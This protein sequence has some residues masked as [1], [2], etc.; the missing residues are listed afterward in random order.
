MNGINNWKRVSALLLCL[1]LFASLLPVSA[2][3]A[4][5]FDPPKLVSIEKQG[6][7]LV[8]TWEKVSGAASYGVWRQT[9]GGSW[10]S[11]AQGVSGPTY[12]DTTVSGG[13]T[14]KYTV[15][16]MNSAGKIASWFDAT[17]LSYYFDW[18][19]ATPTLVSGLATGNSFILK[20]NAVSGASSYSIWR[21]DNSGPWKLVKSGVKG[22]SYTDTNVESGHTYTYT[23]R[24]LDSS[25]KIVSYFDT[26][27]VS[28]TISNSSWAYSTPVL[29]SATYDSGGIQITWDAVKN[30]PYYGIWRK[31]NGGAWQRIGK[32]T[33]TTY[34]DTSAKSGNS[35]IYTVRVQDKNGKVLS[36]FD[37]TGISPTSTTFST[38]KL[39]S[40]ANTS[41]GVELVWDPVAGARK[42]IVFRRDG[43]GP[44]HAIKSGV[45]TNS[46][47]DSNV[48]SGIDY[49]YTVRCLNSAGQWASGFESPG[50]TIRYFPHATPDFTLT[51]TAEGMKIAWPAVSGISSYR[52]YRINDGK[53]VWIDSTNTN[54]YVDKQVVSGNDYTYAVRCQ[55]ADH[56]TLLSW[57]ESNTETYYGNINIITKVSYGE[58]VTGY[59]D[60]QFLRGRSVVVEWRNIQ[61]ADSY[62]IFRKANNAAQWQ[63]LTGPTCPYA[64]VPG[65]DP[66]LFIDNQVVSG[67]TYKYAVRAIDSSG[68]FVGE[69]DTVG[70]TIL[71]YDAPDI[72]ETIADVDGITVSWNPVLG[73]TQYQVYRKITTAEGW[74]LIGSTSDLYFTDKDIIP[75][76]EYQYTVRCVGSDGKTLV[77][78][79]DRVAEAGRTTASWLN[80]PVL[81]NAE[82]YENT[83]T[84]TWLGV[85]LASRYE[86][87]RRLNDESWQHIAYVNDTTNGEISYQD[88]FSSTVSGAVYSYTVR[89]VDSYDNPISNYDK[90]GLQIRFYEVPRIT[91][92]INKTDGVYVEWNTTVNTNSYTIYRKNGDNNWIRIGTS[93]VNHFTDTT[94]VNSLTYVYAISSTDEGS[95]LSSDF[96][97]DNRVSDAITYYKTPELVSVKIE[98]NGL[99]IK[100]AAVDGITDYRLYRKVVGQE[101]V[102]CIDVSGNEYY[103]TTVDS[104][105]TYTYTVRCMVATDVVSEY[106]SNLLKQLYLSVP[107]PATITAP[108]SNS[109]RITWD[110]V[111]GAEYYQIYRK[112][113]DGNWEWIKTVSANVVDYTDTNEIRAGQEY[114]YTIRAKSGDVISDFDATGLTIMTPIS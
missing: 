68:A 12:K 13:N 5:E 4:F 11:I 96:F 59:T 69:Y 112:D 35:Y 95:S 108:S 52:I 38:P 20:W 102:V 44:W 109:V 107:T 14:Y 30:A 91:K 82:L 83:V 113:K 60:A 18:P 114:V 73:I 46:Y 3:A 48:K 104:G 100:W 33:S 74:D 64:D 97:K 89:C 99:K 77:S 15:R 85:D 93:T 66:H 6:D 23:V 16:C 19:C 111:V 63:A 25:G 79:F 103:D 50:L 28:G 32:T 51:S 75:Q 37:T 67:T 22:T 72:Y 24:C 55:T 71:Y 76:T 78:G 101:G 58:D 94:A 90:D 17:G 84:L 54:S 42:Y 36:W 80:T 70:K 88:V 105:T 34:K 92:L 49:T 39:Q 45:T 43:T 2:L 31:T 41:A 57:F 110:A 86:V 53:W 65:T 9:N 40:V 21:K 1:V 61:G 7:A 26:T 87:L 47:V 29:K 98:G 56:K 27:G 62:R 106:D 81:K 10:T 8:L